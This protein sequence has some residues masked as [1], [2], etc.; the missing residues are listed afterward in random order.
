MHVRSRRIPIW[1]PLLLPAFLLL[2]GPAHGG[3][4]AGGASHSAAVLPDGTV[5]VWGAN[6]RGQLGDGTVTLALT[7]KPVPGLA[8]VVAVASGDSHLLALTRTGE[9]WTW[10]ANEAGQL[11]DGTT[12]DR[13]VPLVV[14]SGVVGID[15]GA[16]FSL[17]WKADGSL[18]TWGAND[19][20]QLGD[21]S[22]W[23][24]HTP[25]PITEVSGVAQASAGWGHDDAR[26][27]RGFATAPASRRARG[28]GRIGGNRGVGGGRP[29]VASRLPRRL[30][31]A[32]WQRS[33]LKR[34]TARG[35]GVAR[36]AA[37]GAVAAGSRSHRSG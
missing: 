35:Q 14:L 32:A 26:P 21:G 8:N 24:S 3:I 36:L 13:P 27:D 18:W 37:P 17:A 1:A 34:T 2:T 22:V 31:R 23:S 11:G 16:D 28:D 9:V 15:A 6:D 12:E 33:R 25:A 7:P 5:W 19:S 30:D 4:L 10:G 20:G 29:D